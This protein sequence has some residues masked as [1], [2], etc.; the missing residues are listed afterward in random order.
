M[1]GEKL[2]MTK[3]E[4]ERLSEALKKEEFRK[5]LMDYAEELADPA[6]REVYRSVYYTGLPVFTCTL[7]YIVQ[8]ICVSV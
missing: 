2:D 1:P 5:L 3:E 4:L 6:T 8:C 7:T